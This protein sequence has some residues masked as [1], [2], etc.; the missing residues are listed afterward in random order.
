MYQYTLKRFRW[1]MLIPKYLLYNTAKTKKPNQLKLTN[2]IQTQISQLNQ[3]GVN[4]V[5][6]TPRIAYHNIGRVWLVALP[7]LGRRVKGAFDRAPFNRPLSLPS[8][9]V[10]VTSLHRLL[11]NCTNIW[12]MV[13][14]WQ[15]KTIEKCRLIIKQ[16]NCIEFVS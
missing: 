4:V 13:V 3:S 16:V 8:T 2:K 5:Y 9:F 1:P 11:S 6:W 15:R 12:Y 10:V 14:A 7:P